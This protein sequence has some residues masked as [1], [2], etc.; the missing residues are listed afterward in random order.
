[1]TVKV[2]VPKGR[3][4][5]DARGRKCPAGVFSVNERDPFWARLLRFGDIVPVDAKPVA[6]TK[7]MAVSATKETSPK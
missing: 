3:T 5:L 6:E 7:P 2:T 4:V 1:M